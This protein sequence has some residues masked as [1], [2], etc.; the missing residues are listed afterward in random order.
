MAV[1]QRRPRRGIACAK[2]ERTTMDPE[3]R[4]FA[5]IEVG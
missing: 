3:R 4:L 2:A 5:V 1:E